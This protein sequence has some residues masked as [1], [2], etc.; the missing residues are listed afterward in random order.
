MALWQLYNLN[1]IWHHLFQSSYLWKLCLTQRNKLSPSILSRRRL[2]VIKSFT[3]KEA[4]MFQNIS[5]YLYRKFFS[6]FTRDINLDILFSQSQH[7]IWILF[8]LLNVPSLLI[9]AYCSKRKYN[10]F[11]FPLTSL[12]HSG[13]IKEWKTERG[14][15]ASKQYKFNIVLHLFPP[16]THIRISCSINF[17]PEQKNNDYH[18]FLRR[19]AED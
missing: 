19:F 18:T 3:N 5:Q 17:F 14:F 1:S 10:D 16:H 15:R 11:P 12:G 2:K 13:Y 9:T 8:S 7:E 4:G 6:L